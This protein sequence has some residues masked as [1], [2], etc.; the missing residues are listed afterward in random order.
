MPNILKCGL[1]IAIKIINIVLLYKILFWEREW[2]H[3]FTVK[4]FKYSIKF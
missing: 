3:E 2:L 4:N 1:N